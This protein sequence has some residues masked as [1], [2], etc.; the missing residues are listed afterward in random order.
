ME[1]P[2]A[3]GNAAFRLSPVLS[4]IASY[5]NKQTRPFHGSAIQGI[6]MPGARAS[7]CQVP[8]GHMQISN[9]E[10]KCG[11]GGI[12]EPEKVDLFLYL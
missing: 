9:P 3:P 4:K 6:R 11:Y 10:K 12:C 2:Q 8:G 7:G 1:A 5:V